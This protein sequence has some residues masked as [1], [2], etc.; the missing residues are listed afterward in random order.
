MFSEKTVRPGVRRE[1][2]GALQGAYQ[3]SKR[4]ACSATGFGRSSH[5][6]RSRRASPLA[7][8]QA[9]KDNPNA[10]GTNA[11]NMH[12]ALDA[13]LKQR[14]T[15]YI[16][17]YRMHIWDGVTPVDEIVHTPGNLVRAGK[18]RY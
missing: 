12:R 13:S 7:A 14:G 17:P 8:A 9:G 2:V 18:I 1:V 3:V 15:D 16:D 4:R 6:Y 5:R 11:K 10:G